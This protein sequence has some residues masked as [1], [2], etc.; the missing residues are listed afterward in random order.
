MGKSTSNQ[1]EARRAEIGCVVALPIEIA[2]LLDRC[3]KVRKYSGGSFVFRGGKYR[4]LRLAVVET[5]TG[6]TRAERGTR[7]LIDG[8]TPEWVLSVGFSGALIPEMKP[9]EIIV[10]DEIVDQHGNSLKIDLKM[11]ENR[12][13][14]LYV[15]RLLM[16]DAIIRTVAQ[17]QELQQQTG[18][19]A[20]D[21]ESLAVAQVC[22]ELGTKFMAIRVISDDMSSDLPPEVLSIL[23]G[24]GGIRWGA[25]LGA[26]W[27]RPES[28]KDLWNLRNGAKHAADRLAVFLDTVLEQLARTLS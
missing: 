27:N 28:V 22:R 11:Q 21:L 16:A 24:T 13:G 17:K 18:A 5:G 19:L 15:G 8:H 4:G 6:A 12:S 7:A 10:A 3:E 9:G 20:V 2:P 1:A 25:T 14:G 26:V 23:G